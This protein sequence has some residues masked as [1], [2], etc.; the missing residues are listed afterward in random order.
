M[1]PTIAGGGSTAL[2]DAAALEIL[3]KDLTSSDARPERPLNGDTA[4]TPGKSIL[5]KRL[6]L[7]EALRLPRDATTQVLSTALLA[8]KPANEFAAD[9][10]RFYSGPLPEQRL[11]GWSKATKDFILPY[12]VYRETQTALEWAEANGY[13]DDMMGRIQAEGVVRHFG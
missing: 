13:P 11:A 5:A 12:D 8:P 3:L 10:R 9:V 2:E 1:L 7:W 6:T 4:T